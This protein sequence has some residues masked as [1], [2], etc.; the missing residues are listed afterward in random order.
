[1]SL[2][3]NKAELAD[4]L[5]VSLPT[6]NDWIKKDP[7]F[8]VETRGS[9]GV[10]WKFDPDA[11][12]DYRRLQNEAEIAEANI[13]RERLDQYRLPLGGVSEPSSGAFTPQ[14][15][16]ALVRKRQLEMEMAKEAGFLMQAVEVRQQFR[17]V[18]GQ[19]SRALGSLPGQIGRQFG[20][21]E[22]TI[23]SMRDA[24]EDHQRNMVREMRGLLDDPEIPA[25][26]ET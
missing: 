20:L 21:P 8:P 18:V 5:G 10:E 2:L 14:Q 3:I 4:I 12:I 22:A 19:I 17:A 11:V 26:G 7:A 13:R 16:L 25:D 1:V 24:V 23:L 9:N 15:E 6:L